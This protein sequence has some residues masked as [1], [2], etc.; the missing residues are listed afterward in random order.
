E[1]NICWS[2][3]SSKPT[4]HVVVVSCRYLTAPF[5]TSPPPPPSPPPAAAASQ[6]IRASLRTACSVGSPQKI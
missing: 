1:E 2:L 6:S 3:L 5:S 4:E